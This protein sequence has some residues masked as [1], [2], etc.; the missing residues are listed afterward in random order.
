MKNDGLPPRRARNKR[1]ETPGKEWR[2][3]AHR[4][5]AG[6]AQAEKCTPLRNVPLRCIIP[7]PLAAAAAAVRHGRQGFHNSERIDYALMTSSSSSSSSSI[8]EK[9]QVYLWW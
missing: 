3:A 7:L 6:V 5:R 1:K 2:G 4:S 8:G 9:A